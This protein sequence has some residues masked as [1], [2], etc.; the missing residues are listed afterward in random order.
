MEMSIEDATA[1]LTGPGAPFEIVEQDVLGQR[2]R[3]WKNIPATTRALLLHGRDFGQQ[4]FLVYEDERYSYREFYER[5]AALARVLVERYG[6]E[7]GDRVALAMRNY[8]EWPMAFFA[9]SAVGA[10]VVP[11]NAWWKG[12]ELGYGLS[13]SGS[14]VLICDLERANLIAPELRDLATLPPENVLVVRAEVEELPAGMRPCPQEAPGEGLP[15]VELSPDDDATIFYTSG[16]TGNPKGALGT[17]RNMMTNIGSVGFVRARATLRKGLPLPGPD[18]PPPRN[19]TLVSVPLFHVT[20]SHSML[21]YGT[22][23]GATLVLMHKWSP[24]RALELIE[25]EGVTNFGGVPAMAWQVLESAAF[26]GRDTSSVLGVGYGGA[27]AA[28]ELVRRIGE[29]LPNASPSVGYGLT[30]TSAVTTSNVGLDYQHKPDSIGPAVPVCDVRVVGESGKDMP[31]GEIGE[32]WVRGPNVVRGY[33]NKPEATE[34]S[35]AEGYLHTGDIVSIDADG[36]IRILDRAKDMLIRGGENVYCVEVEDVLYKHPEV[37]DAA[38]IGIPHRVLGEE[39][40]AVV[41]RV[42]GSNVDAETLMAFAAERLAR[43]KVPVHIELRDAPLPR[44]ANGKILKRQLK[45]EL[46]LT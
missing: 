12:G 6:I 13:D 23:I 39:V 40:G 34:K 1:A 32:L 5:T 31:P 7:K 18:E 43:F 30:E 9:A 29:R 26:S 2:L 36:F 19:V 38:V 28:P 42:P 45:D 44:N 8:P 3:C 14:R 11:L 21:A 33:W 17:H 37:M 24:E 20:G 4:T 22:Y 35:F 41:Q 15:E 25:R 27:P 10:I 16:T 46:G